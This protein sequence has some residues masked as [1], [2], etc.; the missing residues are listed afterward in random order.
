MATGT[1][2]Y[3]S[4]QPNAPDAAITESLLGLAVEHAKT[5]VQFDKPIGVHQAIKH[6]CADMAISAQLAYAQTVFAACAIDEGRP[7][8][9]LQA[10]SAHVFAAR[11]AQRASGAT[12]Q[13]HG[14]MGVTFEHDAHLY[15]KRAHVLAAVFGGVGAPTLSRL[16][17]QPTAR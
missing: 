3:A 4:I 8:A 11:A 1:S 12:I 15:M 2:K 13:I 9:E 6:P 10:L 7:D 5:R 14:G 17:A 16:L